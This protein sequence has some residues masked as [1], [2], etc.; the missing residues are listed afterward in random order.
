LQVLSYFLKCMILFSEDRVKD[1]P[2]SPGNY[3]YH[4]SRKDETMKKNLIYTFI[5]GLMAFLFIS[6]FSVQAGES[7][8]GTEYSDPDG[9]FSITVPAGWTSGTGIMNIKEFKAPK[10]SDEEAF[11][12]NI[13]VVA[14]KMASGMTRDRYIEN[15]ATVYM[16]I[17]KIH[18]RE[19]VTVNGV[20]AKRILLDQTIPGQT[21]RVAK[22][23][24][25]KDGYIYILSCAAEL[26]NFEAE[27]PLFEKVVGTFT[28]LKK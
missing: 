24:I 13:K 14:A 8:P 26:K 11:Q 15:S 23:F 28:I 19:D 27:L 3:N 16:D 9:F 2:T 6:G 7:F 12:N 25:E 17:W 21:T 5:T 20:K 22:Y 10:K 4:Q 1:T 18:K